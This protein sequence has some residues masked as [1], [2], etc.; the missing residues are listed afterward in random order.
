[1]IKSIKTQR[2]KVKADKTNSAMF[3]N[4][5]DAQ[6]FFHR[7]GAGVHKPKKGKGSYTRKQKHR[8]DLYV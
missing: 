6:L 5:S 4:R 7:S 1:M 2:V 8:L 3:Q